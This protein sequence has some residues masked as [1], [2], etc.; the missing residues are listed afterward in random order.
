MTSVEASVRERRRYK[1][2]AFAVTTYPDQPCEVE[3]NRGELRLAAEVM[4]AQARGG[5]VPAVVRARA[6]RTIE[7]LGE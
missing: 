1:R 5:F 4:I 2:R 7:R 3:F 6:V